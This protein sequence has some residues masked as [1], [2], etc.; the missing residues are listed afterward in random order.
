MR[1]AHR[2][3]GLPMQERCYA[4]GVLINLKCRPQLFPQ[5]ERL[6]ERRC[7]L[8]DGGTLPRHQGE[9]GEEND[10]GGEVRR[11]RQRNRDAR[12]ACKQQQ[13][14]NRA[15]DAECAEEGEES[16]LAMGSAAEGLQRCQEHV[17]CR[18]TNN[19]HHRAPAW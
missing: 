10:R 12:H 4:P 16:T 5:S 6:I 18:W 9:A 1:L 17:I 11:V 15:R 7:R 3:T 13:Q 19:L 8:L 14:C 2:L